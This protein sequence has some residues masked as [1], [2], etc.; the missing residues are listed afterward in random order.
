MCHILSSIKPTQEISAYE[1]ALFGLWTELDLAWCQGLYAL[2]REGTAVGKLLGRLFSVLLGTQFTFSPVFS[3]WGPADKWSSRSTWFGTWNF[4]S[5]CACHL[6]YAH[7]EAQSLGWLLQRAERDMASSALFRF[8]FS[9]LPHP[10]LK[11]CVCYVQYSEWTRRVSEGNLI[12]AKVLYVGS[13]VDGKQWSFTLHNNAGK[14]DVRKE[15]F[16]S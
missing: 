2:V 14:Q 15:I 3:P 8:C 9:G 12:S 10:L 11:S 4:Q 16:L 6:Y 13:Q 7:G 5:G 1:T